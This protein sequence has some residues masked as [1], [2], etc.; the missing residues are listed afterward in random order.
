MK[1]LL[2]SLLQLWRRL[3]SLTHRRRLQREMEEEMRFHLEM[4][5]EQNMESGMATEEAR[6]AAQRQFGNQTWLKEV[7]REMWGMRSIETLIQDLRF[8]A[9]IFVKNPGFTLIAVITLSLGIG[10]NTAIF[11]VINTVLLRPLPFNEPE[12]LMTLWASDLRRGDQSSLS[13]PNFIDWRAQSQS[14]EGMAAFRTGN[15]VLMSN[16]G[17]L[18]LI[19]TVASAELFTQLG[20]MPSVGRSFRIEEDQPGANVVILSHELWERH[21]NSDRQII[22]R[23]ITLNSRNLTVVGVM[24]AGFQF[25]IGADQIELWTTIAY[26]AANPDGTTPMAIQRGLGYLKA[27]GRLKPQVTLAQAQA[28]I[29]AVA[30]RLEQQYPDDNAH[31]GVRIVPALE[32]LVGDMRRPLLILFGAVAFVLLI[33]CANVANLLLARWSVRRREMAIRA[34]LGAN[35][36]R[37]VRQVL[38]ESI[39]LALAGGIGGGLIAL[40]GT[41]LLITLSPENIPRLQEIRLSGP[42][43]VFTLLISLLTGLLFGL[44][45]AAHAS[46]TALTGSLNEGGRSGYE[47]ARGNRL[48][49]GLVIAEIAIALMLMI[50]AG[51][52]LTSFWRLSKVDPGFNPQNVL[53]LRISLPTSKYSISQRIAFYEQ[54]QARLQ[55]LP[56]VRAASASWFLPLSGVNPSLDIEIDGRPT[57][58][59][60]RPEID[61]H[62]IMP[63]YFRTL[64]IRLLSGRDFTAHDNTSGRPVVMIN[65]SFQRQY[66]PN[67][68][69]LGKRIRPMVSINAGEPDMR[70]IIGVVSNVKHRGISSDAPPVIYLPLAQLPITSSMTIV[71]GANVDSLGLINGARAEVH[72][73]DKELPVYEVKPLDWYFNA[74]VAPSRFNALLLAI[75]AGLALLLTSIGLYGVMSYSVTQ[76]THEIGLR[77]ALGAQTYD[78]QYLIIRQGM[79]LAVI[80]VGLGLLGALLLTRMIEKLLFSVNPTDPAMFALIALLLILVVLLACWIP[81]RRATKVDPITALRCE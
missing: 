47:G 69:P 24:P 5:I 44:A 74:A 73:L 28:E 10:A 41:N 50:G 7:C 48:R 56:G 4:Q 2:Q 36:V 39:M 45:P 38:T 59:G 60:E 66:L 79:K 9:R 8:G 43:F 42:V 70:E 75:F 11:S 23:T 53:T 16:D 61:S 78:V 33:A 57:R 3:L 17:P 63:D 80:G 58:P 30:R 51:L 25:P 21:F 15:F 52:L 29:D 81:A 19:G 6:R 55:Q 22:G 64:G 62:F 34:A 65:E 68:D 67:E 40:W 13:Y 26:D 27:I 76:R 18:R 14:F 1:N 46:K 54:L 20:V 35:R 12:R 77:V 31:Q 72:A 71:I 49:G 32:Q 37:V